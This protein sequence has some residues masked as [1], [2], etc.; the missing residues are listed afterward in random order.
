MP[1]TSSWIHSRS[2][3]VLGLFQPGLSVVHAQSISDAFE[4][5]RMV[6][7]NQATVLNCSGVTDALGQR[8]VDICSGGVRA[9]DG[10][11]SHISATVVLFA[12]ALARIEAA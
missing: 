9:M 6:R 2:A 12:P 1:L 4:V 8:L 7:S 10:Q 11:I 5:L 3:P